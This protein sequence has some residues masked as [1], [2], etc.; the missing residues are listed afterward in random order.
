MHTSNLI[1]LIIVKR[2]NF[3]DLSA[4]RNYNIFDSKQIFQLISTILFKKL[5]VF[6]LILF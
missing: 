4:S 5:T 6:Y 1:L 2:F 3:N